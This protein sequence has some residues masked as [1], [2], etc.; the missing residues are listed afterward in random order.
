VGRAV[1]QRRKFRISVVAYQAKFGSSTSDGMSVHESYKIT[2]PRQEASRVD[3]ERSKCYSIFPVPHA[4]DPENLIPIYPPP[5]CVNYSAPTKKH[6]QHT[7]TEIQIKIEKQ[8]QKKSRSHLIFSP[9]SR[10]HKL[11]RSGHGLIHV[12]HHLV[13]IETNARKRGQKMLHCSHSKLTYT[14]KYDALYYIF[15]FCII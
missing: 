9:M 15:L 13:A 10:I 7:Q 8:R 3:C 5:T 11:S 6:T 1:D 2:Y 12:V 14:R 4:V